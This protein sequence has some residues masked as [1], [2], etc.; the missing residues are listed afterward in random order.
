MEC[1]CSLNPTAQ[2]SS[3]QTGLVGSQPA[4]L[5]SHSSDKLL[6]HALWD[7]AGTSTL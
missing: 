3:Q 2:A 7:P 1:Y 6:L 4:R 5:K